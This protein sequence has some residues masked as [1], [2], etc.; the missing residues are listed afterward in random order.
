MIKTCKTALTAFALASLP[1]IAACGEQDETPAETAT[2]DDG[3]L[4]LAAGLGADEQLDTLRR[5]I[6]QSEL[7]GV[8]EGAASY[9]MLAPRDAAFE[10]LGEE[11]ADLLR[12]EQRL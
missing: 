5:A 12:E 1:L 6:E 10:A 3:T 11:G 8:F 9:T 4:T 2:R 7:S